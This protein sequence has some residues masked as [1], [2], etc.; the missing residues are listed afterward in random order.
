MRKPSSGKTALTHE[1]I[2]LLLKL[3]IDIHT[4]DRTSLSTLQK[5]KEQILSKIRDT[6]RPLLIDVFGKEGVHETLLLCE[7]RLYLQLEGQ[8]RLFLCSGVKG[9]ND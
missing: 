6:D 9:Q 8:R 2:R 5:N 7:A 4:C 3:L 1:E